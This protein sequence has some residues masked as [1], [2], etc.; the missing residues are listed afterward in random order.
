MFAWQRHVTTLGLALGAHAAAVAATRWAPIRMQ[1][2]G[3]ALAPET[4][5]IVVD[6]APAAA[7]SAEQVTPEWPQRAGSAAAIR[8]AARAPS[9]NVEGDAPTKSAAPATAAEP[10]STEPW[11]VWSGIVRASPVA[12]DSHFEPP[13]SAAPERPTA[14]DGVRAALD[15]RDR[16]LGLGADGPLISVIQSVTLSSRV[17]IESS[18][19]VF[20]TV[21]GDGS[22]V[23]ARATSGTGMRARGTMS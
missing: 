19:V 20:V 9:R 15:E 22:V 12:G 3:A 13:G 16:Q 23:S 17:A 8:L 4:T 1:A 5:V 10:T 6:V 18:A 21:D 2:V 11:S 7:P 14:V